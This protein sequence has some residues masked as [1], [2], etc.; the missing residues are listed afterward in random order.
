ME[1]I[2]FWHVSVIHHL[3]FP[4]IFSQKTGTHGNLIGM[5]LVKLKETSRRLT[6]SALAWERNCLWKAVFVLNLRSFY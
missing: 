3:N 1:A 5:A 6:V 4:P 2:L